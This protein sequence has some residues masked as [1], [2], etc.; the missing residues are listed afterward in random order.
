[1]NKIK[2]KVF[3]AHNIENM[4]YYNKLGIEDYDLFDYHN[5]IIKKNGTVKNKFKP[6]EHDI[7]EKDKFELDD[8]EETALSMLV[9]STR[10]AEDL[11]DSCKRKEQ[12]YKSMLIS[13][14][15]KEFNENKLFESTHHQCNLSPLGYCVYKYN[16]NELECIFCGE[17][18]ERK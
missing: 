11:Y 18:E 2:V 1:M 12:R 14:N 3:N 10:K 7:I 8:I 5:C 16:D 9:H 4:E 13:K 6:L 17:P 15:F